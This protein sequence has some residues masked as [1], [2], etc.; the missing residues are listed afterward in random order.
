MPSFAQG[1]HVVVSHVLTYW[2]FAQK[3]AYAGEE[4]Q[5]NLCPTQRGK[6][7]EPGEASK[8]LLTWDFHMQDWDGQTFA[9]LCG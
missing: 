7:L 3:T 2:G 4:N 5:D 8:L 9:F 6:E 1:P